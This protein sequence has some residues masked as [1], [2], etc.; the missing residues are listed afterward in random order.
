V[1]RVEEGV[2]SRNQRS[3]DVARIQQ[4]EIDRSWLHRLLG[5]ASLRIE[6]AGSSSE[7]EV[8]LRVVT[9][10]DA[11]ALRDAVRESKARV[12][13]LPVDADGATP[14]QTSRELLRVPTSHV[15][16]AA[17]TGVRCWSCPRSSPVRCSSW[18]RTPARRSTAV[19]TCS[20]TPACSA[21]TGCRLRPCP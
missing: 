1:L 4:V 2:L 11:L 8:E 18:A 9:E 5:M 21:R 6:T 14:D 15:V 13:G 16:L 10:A 17:V 3:L 7:V 19:S 12:T 20:P